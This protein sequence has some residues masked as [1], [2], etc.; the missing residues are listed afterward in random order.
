MAF[1]SN[2]KHIWC[3]LDQEESLGTFSFDDITKGDQELEHKLKVIMLETEVLRQDGKPVPP[4][5]F[6]TPQIWEN[7]LNLPSRASRTKHLEFLFKTSKKRE[8][9]LVCIKKQLKVLI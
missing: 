6:M 3:I 9:R 1:L 4:D 5:E 7:L 8:N 2:S